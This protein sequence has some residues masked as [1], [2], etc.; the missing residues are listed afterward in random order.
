MFLLFLCCFCLFV[1]VGFWGGFLVWD[2]F[3]GFFFCFFLFFF[4]FCFVFF[5]GGGG[6]FTVM[7]IYFK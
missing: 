1:V 5:F 3:V 6:I 7:Y 4:V 2:C